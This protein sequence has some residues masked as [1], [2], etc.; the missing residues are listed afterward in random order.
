MRVE[1]YPQASLIARFG[2]PVGHR[3]C[4]VC[5]G[6]RCVLHDP[7]RPEQVV[8][9][10]RPAGHHRRAPQRH[11]LRSGNLRREGRKIASGKL[12]RRDGRTG[13]ALTA[14]RRPM[15][16]GTHDG[17][18]AHMRVEGYPEVSLIATD[19]TRR[20]GLN[21]ASDHLG[22]SGEVRVMVSSRSSIGLSDMRL[23]A[24]GT[25][26]NIHVGHGLNGDDHDARCRRQTHVDH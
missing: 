11:H 6:L 9:Y 20:A 5:R 13:Q 1:G 17:R 21:R 18:R 12:E 15:S 2:P 7:Y 22:G 26:L 4:A 8:D 23:A 3:D 16:L 25:R 10:H 14:E 24:N 19:P